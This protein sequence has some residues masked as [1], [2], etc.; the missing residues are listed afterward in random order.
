MSQLWRLQPKKLGLLSLGAALVIA[1]VALKNGYATQAGE[2]KAKNLGSLSFVLGWVVVAYA[3]ASDENLNLGE[4]LKTTRGVLS[5]VSSVVILGS[6]MTMMEE[7]K[8]KGK[9][10]PKWLGMLFVVGWIGL[11]VS[12][13]LRYLPGKGAFAGY[14]KRPSSY[15]GLTAS[16]LVLLA[17]TVVL[18]R[19]RKK[20]ITDG[21]GMPLFTAGWAFLALANSLRYWRA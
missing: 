20:K 1:G 17:M 7:Y 16:F 4:G 19:E 15:L 2:K 11:G 21:F 9:P 14:G 10:A 13:G 5:L 8:D 3:T 12:V 18:P 6:V